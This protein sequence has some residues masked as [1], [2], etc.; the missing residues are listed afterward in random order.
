MSERISQL[1]NFL[2]ETPQ[3]PFLLYALATEYAKTDSKKALA[4]FEQLVSQ[5]PQ[6]VGTY[7]HL[8]QLY[9]D[10]EE[11]E[12]AKNTYEKGLEILEN[13]NET[14]LLQELKNA[15]QNFLFENS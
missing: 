10:L 8:A 14:K 2:Q 11:S 12:K 7:Y 4:Y 15:Y 3:E 5:H 6:Y 1:L 9:A 13:A